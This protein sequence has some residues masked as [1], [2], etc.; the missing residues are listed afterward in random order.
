MKFLIKTDK[1]YVAYVSFSREEKE[2]ALTQFRDD[3]KV[4]SDQSTLHRHLTEIKK[5]YP[6]ARKVVA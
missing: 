5:K 2:F 1:G 3:A 6:E 4:Y